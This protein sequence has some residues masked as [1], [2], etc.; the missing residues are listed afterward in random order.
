M[1]LIVVRL[2]LL[3]L[4]VV[5]SSSC[6]TAME[7][8]T[9]DENDLEYKPPKKVA[10][11]KKDNKS[12]RKG[13]Q[14]KEVEDYEDIPDIYEV[15]ASTDDFNEVDILLRSELEEANFKIVKVS[16]VTKGMK[17]QGRKDFW[18]DMNIY[19]VC[20]LSD[21]YFIL[22]RNPHLVGFCPYRIYTY[23]DKEGQIVV[24]FVKPSLAISYMGVVDIKAINLFKKH[25]LQLKKILDDLSK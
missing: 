23:R 17:E 19:L 9:D 1:F 5:F 12:G 20:K 11:F 24:G 6:I 13:Y 15:V 4:V 16:H 2:F 22:K 21:G 18:E 10:V 25:D 3:L 8:S 7:W 14:K